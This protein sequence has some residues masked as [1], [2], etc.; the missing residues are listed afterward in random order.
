MT[1]FLGGSV[2]TVA[3]NIEKPIPIANIVQNFASLDMCFLLR[4]KAEDA[5][6]VPKSVDCQPSAN[7]L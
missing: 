1:C 5:D 4:C 3:F 2:S 6:D 7:G